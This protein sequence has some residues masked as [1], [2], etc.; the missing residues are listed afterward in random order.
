MADI[1]TNSK[2]RGILLIK[3]VAFQEHRHL[4]LAGVQGVCLA[5]L[6]PTWT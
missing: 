2:L 3:R 6:A 5:R 4:D 1:P